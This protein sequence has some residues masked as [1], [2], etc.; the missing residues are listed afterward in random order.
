[1][2]PG[3]ESQSDVEAGLESE[4]SIEMG[5]NAITQVPPR[6]KETSAVS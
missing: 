2:G 4:E 5:G 3:G 1:M 6:M